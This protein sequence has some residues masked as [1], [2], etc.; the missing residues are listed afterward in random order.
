MFFVDFIAAFAVFTGP[1]SARADA[2]TTLRRGSPRRERMYACSITSADLAAIKTIQNE[3][4]LSYAD[5]LQQ[6]LAARK[7]LLSKTIH[8]AEAERWSRRKMD[9]NNADVDPSLQNLKNQ[10]SDRIDRALSHIMIST[11]GKL[12]NAGIS[13]T[14][15]IAKEVLAMAGE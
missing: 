14:E 10:W 2:T 5:E 1:K 4:S 13:G 11:R 8:C 12:N 15:S 6:E 3:P 7:N 9:L